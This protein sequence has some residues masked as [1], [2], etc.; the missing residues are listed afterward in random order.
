MSAEDL[1]RRCIRKEGTLSSLAAC[2]RTA[3][4]AAAADFPARQC[5]ARPTWYARFSFWNSHVAHTLRAAFA[6]SGSYSG[7]WSRRVIGVMI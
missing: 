6:R 7:G 5:V 3:L 1:C 4:S 2:A